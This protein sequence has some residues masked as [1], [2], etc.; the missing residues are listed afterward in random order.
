MYHHKR[1][2]HFD[3]KQNCTA[4]NYSHSYPNKKSSRAWKVEENVD[5]CE[6]YVDILDK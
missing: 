2:T 3:H 4:H 6:S 5:V 1:E